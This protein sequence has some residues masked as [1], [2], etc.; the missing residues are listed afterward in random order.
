MK[1]LR[2]FTYAAT[3]FIALA[4]I[5]CANKEKFDEVTELSLVRCL[6]PM[7]L[8]AKV[9]A[10]LGDVVTFSWDVAKD[11]QSY[12]LSVY[13]DA[14]LSDVFFSETLEPSQVPYTVKLDADATYYS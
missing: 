9:N 13:T 8:E 3:A 7:N 11:A 6:T 10:N 5:S 1:K 12:V 4:A 14:A 2:I